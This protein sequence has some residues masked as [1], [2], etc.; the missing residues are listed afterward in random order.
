MAALFLLAWLFVL[1]VHAEDSVRGADFAIDSAITAENR[2]DRLV[3]STVD[4]EE[5]T[6][7]ND[8]GEPLLMAYWQDPEFDPKQRAFYYVRVLEIPTAGLYFAH[9]VRPR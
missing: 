9:L 6:Y 3:G 7:A 2:C 8:I 1:G 5:A 4:V